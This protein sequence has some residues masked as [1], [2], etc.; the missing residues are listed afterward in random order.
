M[1]LRQAGFMYDTFGSFTHT[2]THTLRKFKQ[3][4]YSRYIY[5]NQQDKARFQHMTHGIYKDLPR[6]R[7]CNKVLHEKAFAIA[8]NPKENGYQGGHDSMVYKLFDK[9]SRDTTRINNYPI[10]YTS[11]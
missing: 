7:A 10:N 2:H 5:Q 8:S 9:K 1:Y 3:A 6:K 11:Q 4:C